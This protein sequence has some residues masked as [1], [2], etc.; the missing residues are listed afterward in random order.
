MVTQWRIGG[1][2]GL[3]AR[4]EREFDEG[5]KHVSSLIV[6]ADTFRREDHCVSCWGQG[7]ELADGKADDEPD[8]EQGPVG[9]DPLFWWFTHR[10]AGKKQ[11]L[12]LDLASLE[13]LF[14]QLGGREEVQVRELRYLL[15]LLL[16][17]KRRL[18]VV[19]VKRTA[20]GEFFHV[21]RPRRTENIAVQV[22]DF[23]AERMAELRGQ[24]QEVFDGLDPEGGVLSGE[25]ASGSAA[26]GGSAAEDAST[27][28]EDGSGE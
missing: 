27:G 1:R 14:L 26:E 19:Q 8:G 11:G 2:T 17:R 15:C 22:Y 6:E 7:P 21:R 23:T 20:E 3:C 9:A 13:H 16:M 24:L 12:Q 4:C 18:K 5:E 25:T 28:G 10:R